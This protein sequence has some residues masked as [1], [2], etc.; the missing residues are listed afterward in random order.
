[1]LDKSITLKFYKRKDIQEE[2]V[3]HAEN[4]EVGLRYND[5]FGKRPDILT[6]PRDVLELALKGLTSVHASEELWDNPITLN[7][8]LSKK[9]LDELRIGWDLVLDIDCAIMEYSR[10]CADLIIKFLKYCG[11]KN[12]S[13]KFSGNKGFHLGVPFEAFPKQ[14]GDKLTKDLFPEAPK[15]IAF[16]IQENIK[17]ELS[18]RILQFENN[19]VNAVR[20]K[21]A[22]EDLIRYEKDQ[23]GNNLT[24]LSVDKFLEI[25]TVLISS[26]HLY[27]MPYSLHEKS[28]LVSLPIDPD[29][30]LEF[31]KH[32]AQPEKILTPMFTFL[33][34]KVQ[35]E[36]ARRLLVQALDFEIKLEPEIEK[37]NFE[38]VKIESAIKEDFF[39]PCIKKMLNGL[40]D[41]KKR[42]V[43]ILSN[44]LGKIG[45]NRTEIEQF[46]QAWNNQN[47]E[48]LRE[49]YIKGQLNSFKP[50]EKLPPNCSNEAY[51]KGIDICRPD[52]LCSKIKNPVNYTLIRWR[53]WLRD[54]EKNES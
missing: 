26:R 49:V 15:K 12:I 41:G 42:G 4:K 5:S 33:D 43:F 39:P 13:C 24:K 9:E 47:Q 45:W 35:E 11:V 50:G 23:Y 30:V 21:V 54:N 18:K 40:A 44:F 53:R 46:I 32:M 48:K 52:S 19:D 51:Y 22:V 27:R 28:K 38:E 14:V 17:E 25:D 20:E 7:S 31:E 3:K 34:R 6:Y 36:S 16:Y 29:K 8:N 1:M 2:L 37:K 10:I